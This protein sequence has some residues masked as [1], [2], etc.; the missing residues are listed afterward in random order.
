MSEKSSDKRLSLS[1]FKDWMKPSNQNG[2]THNPKLTHSSSTAVVPRCLPSS[3]PTIPELCSGSLEDPA[4]PYGLDITS[5]MPQGFLHALL[6]DPDP[7]GKT[8][9]LKEGE[10]PTPTRFQTK[11]AEGVLL[12]FLEEKEGSLFDRLLRHDPDMLSSI[13]PELGDPA[14]V[15]ASI[16]T[17]QEAAAEP[18][19]DSH[20]KQIYF[21]LGDGTFHLL[22]VVGSS[23]LL[24]EMGNKITAM[25]DGKGVEADKRRFYNT[26]RVG[27]GGSKPQNVSRLVSGVTLIPSIPPNRKASEHPYN[28]RTLFDKWASF[29]EVKDLF[30]AMN[31]FL[32]GNPPPNQKTRAKRAGYMG[33]IAENLLEY[34]A[35][36]RGKPGWTDTPHC[37]LPSHQKVWLDPAAQSEHTSEE[38]L[39]LVCEEFAQVADRMLSDVTHGSVERRFW[40]DSLSDLCQLEGIS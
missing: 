33:Q 22:G 2:L 16:K 31:G 36:L 35:F 40:S 21:P 26:I 30:S 28:K 29:R 6:H 13:P 37:T 23:L 1:L 34:R 32:A 9:I 17:A 25:R 24:K 19:A 4:S 7:M 15:V 18:L 38:V 39:D 14:E 5:G 11:V 27:F 12:P 20:L 8:Q 10:K 3:I